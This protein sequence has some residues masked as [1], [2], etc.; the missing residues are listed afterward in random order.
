M[1]RRPPRST[2]TEPLFPSPTP[3]RSGT[4]I[5]H[6][7]SQ[8]RLADEFAELL[9]SAEDDAPATTTT[10]APPDPASP[11][12]TT[13]A[14]ATVP[15]MEPVPEGTDIAHI[16][17]PKIGVAEPII[18]GVE[19]ADLTHGPGTFPHTP[20]PGQEGNAAR[21]DERRGGQECA[22]KL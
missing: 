2:R 1:L 3:F 9:D 20:P 17:L 5:R 15:P 7:Q 21:K 10:T 11:T 6:A 14:P 19:L 4:G 18:A 16:R 12:S 13:A 8:E 22:R